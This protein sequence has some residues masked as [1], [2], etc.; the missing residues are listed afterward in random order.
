MKSP[1]EKELRR[2]VKT[3]RSDLWI[4]IAALLASAGLIVIAIFAPR[5]SH[6]EDAPKP[7]SK[8]PAEIPDLAGIWMLDREHSDDPSK[9]RPPGGGAGGHHGGW[10]GGGGGM[11]GGMGGWGGGGGH[12][13]GGWGGGEGGGEGGPPPGEGSG[14]GG[15]D[16]PRPQ[17]QPEKLM[18]FRKGDAFQID[19]GSSRERELDWAADAPDTGGVIP[20]RW[21]GKKLVAE[22]KSER[23]SRSMTYELDKDGKAL[24]VT[25][26]FQRPEGE[27]V[28]L[29]SRYT[30]YEG[31][32]P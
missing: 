28:S 2:L 9:L 31:T 18:V 4:L 11:S 7:P 30:K 5:V 32:E 14:G 27:S 21:D 22:M 29:K 8:V 15:G 10:S 24:T 20:S 17:P 12:H 23:G 6:A 25:M 26:K 16:H 13:N 19:D 1:E 3:N